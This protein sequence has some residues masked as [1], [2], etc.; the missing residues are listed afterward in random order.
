MPMMKC[1]IVGC[2]NTMTFSKHAVRPICDDHWGKLTP[3]IQ[4]AMVAAR[5]HGPRAVAT[6]LTKARQWIKEIN[7]ST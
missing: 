3:E 4:K 1:A 5:H 7:N 2:V 6:E